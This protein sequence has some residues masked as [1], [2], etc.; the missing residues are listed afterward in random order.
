MGGKH[1]ITRGINRNLYMGI[2]DAEFSE[3][4][5]TFKVL[6]SPMPNTDP[7][8]STG[9]RLCDAETKKEVMGRSN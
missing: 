8:D 7:G 3:F 5:I 2:F 4:G 1:I 6:P 9:W